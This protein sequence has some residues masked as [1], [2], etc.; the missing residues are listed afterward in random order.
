MGSSKA[1]PFFHFASTVSHLFLSFIFSG[2]VLFSSSDISDGISD[3]RNWRATIQA[4]SWNPCW[5]I[6]LPVH[7]LYSFYNCIRT[8]HIQ[9]LSTLAE[10]IKVGSW[11]DCK[12]EFFPVKIINVIAQD[13]E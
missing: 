3:A 12:L 9:S 2:C 10:M 13:M 5:P 11:V 6:F 8:V 1:E 7:I 4:S